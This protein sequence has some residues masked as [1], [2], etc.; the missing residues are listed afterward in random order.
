MRDPARRHPEERNQHTGPCG[1]RRVRHWVDADSAARNTQVTKSITEGFGKHRK[2]HLIFP[3]D[4]L[5]SRTTPVRIWR[6]AASMAS[7]FAGAGS[8][9]GLP[10]ILTDEDPR[11]ERRYLVALDT[12]SLVASGPPEPESGPELTLTFPE[13][14]LPVA[15]PIN[16]LDPEPA[17]RWAKRLRPGYTRGVERKG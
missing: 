2:I 1:A 6:A 4:W 10:S 11:D 3:S 9:S 17:T 14:F 13:D 5:G 12:P 8:G 7:A 16:G 15:G